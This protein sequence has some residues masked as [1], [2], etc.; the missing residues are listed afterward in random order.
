MSALLLKSSAGLS[1]LKVIATLH[2]VIYLRQR[3]W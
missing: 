2:P 1:K 3:R